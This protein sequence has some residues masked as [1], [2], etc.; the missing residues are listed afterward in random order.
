MSKISEFAK[1]LGISEEE[2]ISDIFTSKIDIDRNLIW[3][4]YQDI[5]EG[6]LSSK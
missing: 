4:K 6:I 2:F 1:T 5:E 3:E